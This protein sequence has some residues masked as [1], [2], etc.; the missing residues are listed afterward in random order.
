MLER[1]TLSRFTAFEDA[2]LS[3]SR[4]VNVFIGA[5]ATGKTHVL[6]LA[7]SLL[8]AWDSLRVKES[9][10]S[11]TYGNSRKLLSEEFVFSVLIASL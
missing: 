1:L 4:G 5:N 3:F 2:T 9:P 8:R 10:T 11:R 7:Y 6:K